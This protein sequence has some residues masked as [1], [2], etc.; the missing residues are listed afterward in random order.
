M[1]VYCPA[2]MAEAWKKYEGLRC[3]II[4][5]EVAY[6]IMSLLLALYALFGFVEGMYAVLLLTLSTL[7]L[8]SNYSIST[9][10]LKFLN[11]FGFAKIFKSNPRYQRSFCISR[12]MEV[13][14]ESMRFIVGSLCVLLFFI[15]FHVCIVK[16]DINEFR[17]VIIAA[18]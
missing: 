18:A 9:F 8:G 7:L 16:I 5:L 11:L 3:E 6:L 15:D 2:D 10:F 14:E 17:F 4:R 13:F 1:T 12:E